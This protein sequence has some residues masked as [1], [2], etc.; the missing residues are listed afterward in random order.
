MRKIILPLVLLSNLAF[1]QVKWDKLPQKL[2]LYPRN[3]K[4]SANV[5][6]S[7]T[8]SNNTYDSIIV[9][10]FKEAQFYQRRAIMLNYTNSLARFNTNIKIKAELSNYHFKIYGSKNNNKTLLHQADSVVAGDVFVITGQS[11]ATGYTQSN[12]ANSIKNSY[13][14][15]FGNAIY[16]ESEKTKNDTLWGIANAFDPKTAWTLGLFTIGDWG[17]KLGNLLAN[18]TKIPVCIFNGAVGGTGIGGHQQNYNLGSIYGRIY[19]RLLKSGLTNNVKAFLWHQGESDTNPNGASNYRDSF[20]KM[21]SSWQSDFKGISKIYYF[22]IRSATYCEGGSGADLREVQR[23][24]K[25]LN[26]KLLEPMST[27]WND[28]L[29]DDCH[30]NTDGY[31]KI[32]ESLYPMLIRDIYADRNLLLTKDLELA[33]APDILKAYYTS[34]NEIVLEL[35]QN[36]IWPIDKGAYKMIDYL[37]FD[38]N[39]KVS[40]AM[41]QNKKI[42]L[43]VSSTAKAKQ[44]SYL[45]RYYNNTNTLYKGPYIS[46]EKGVGLFAFKNFPIESQPTNLENFDNNNI[47]LNISPNPTSD[48]L[49]VNQLKPNSF[50]E[51]FN[52]MGNLVFKMHAINETELVDVINYSEGFYLLR[53]ESKTIKFIKH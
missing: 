53:N 29:S 36:V 3:E 13:V 42:Y 26:P 20:S 16:S 18:A 15:S 7:G 21:I 1:S 34:A 12:G 28:M 27:F 45:N 14:R 9:E 2:A 40:S 48:V 32:A 47:S 8:V 30:F 31:W 25:T 11:N 35:S 4:D 33:G 52:S 38:N 17:L 6:F 43:E 44:I 37:Y 24:L 51:I 10:S 23:N 19:Y 50:I 5:I 22:Q 49:Q 39:T 46:N 41:V